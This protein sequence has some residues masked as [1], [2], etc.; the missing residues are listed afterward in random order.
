MY[1]LSTEQRLLGAVPL[2]RD[3][4]FHICRQSLYGKVV[5]V[6]DKPNALLA[7]GRKQWLRLIRKMQVE[8][9]RTLDTERIQVLTND[10]ARMQTVTF[11]A[12]VPDDIGGTLPAH[13]T[14]MDAVQCK[15]FAPVCH[16]MYITY[17]F[18][19]EHLHMMT[20]WMPR[21][22]LVVIYEQR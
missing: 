13:V 17:T 19:R 20:S 18:P 8:R 11:S 15:R 7:S 4:A 22:G 3:L 16:T 5:V 14:F 9:A 6:T 12:T 2:S 1:G 21:N 10:L